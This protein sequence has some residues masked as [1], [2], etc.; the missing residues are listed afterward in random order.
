MARPGDHSHAADFISRYGPTAV[1][2]GAGRG[3]GSAYAKALAARGLDLVL[4]DID[5]EAVEAGAARLRSETGRPVPVVAADMPD[6]KSPE[7]LATAAEGLDVGLVICNHLVPSQAGRF[8]EG[9]ADLYRD[10]IGANVCAYVELAN[11]FGRRLQ[12]RGRGG[13][14]I[15]SSM[16]GVVGSPYVTTYGASKAFLL[17]FGSALAY[18]LRNSG[19]DVLTLVPGAVNTDTYKKAE[20]QQTSTFR[21]MDVDEF[22]DEALGALGSKRVTTPGRKNAMTAALLGRLLPR[23]VAVSVMGRN[24]EKL[25]G[26]G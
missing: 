19:V 2:T 7:L 25:L 26:Q 21:P 5:S 13:L 20:K 8:L 10:E 3:I 14:L 11:R 22:V 18:E 15:M 9:D 1:V 6:P 24:L 16:T 23:S 17:A 4:T 12:E